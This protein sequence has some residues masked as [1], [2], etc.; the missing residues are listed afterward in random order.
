MH[1]VDNQLTFLFKFFSGN[2]Y[3]CCVPNFSAQCPVEP[4]GVSYVD[5]QAYQTD[6]TDSFI[7]SI[8]ACLHTLANVHKR[9]CVWVFECVHMCL[10]V[11]YKVHR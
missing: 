4:R 6:S 5:G 9:V 3:S 8:T 1:M 7:E 11:W 10:C 2:V